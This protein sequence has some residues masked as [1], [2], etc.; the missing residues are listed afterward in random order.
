MSSSSQPPE[1]PS[2]PRLDVGEV[3][4]AE[5]A[6]K[7]RVRTVETAL[8]EKT[9]QAS[10]GQLATFLLAAPG[11]AWLLFYLVAPVIFIVLVSFW[12]QST[13][14]FE[15]KWTLDNYDRLFSDG[16]YWRTLRQSVF[17]S[18]IVVGATFV[19]VSRSPTSLR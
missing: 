11:T 13:S 3:E 7:Q 5:E 6:L 12:T 18:L 19:M 14:G 9:T 8:G 1:H 17:N 16:T 4:E 10:G 2:A 15:E